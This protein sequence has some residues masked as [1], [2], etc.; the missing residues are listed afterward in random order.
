MT[1]VGGRVDRC[2]GCVRVVAASPPCLPQGTPRA[3]SRGTTVRGEQESVSRRFGARQGCA[4]A[5]QKDQR[6]T[7]PR[8]CRPQPLPW[9]RVVHLAASC[10]PPFLG[11]VSHLELFLS[12]V[13]PLQGGPAASSMGS[14]QHPWDRLCRQL[15][16]PCLSVP[17]L[18]S[19]TVEE[20]AGLNYI[21]AKT[22]VF[23]CP[24]RAHSSSLFST[25]ESGAVAFPT[26]QVCGNGF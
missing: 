18:L 19:G 6:T 5:R 13:L 24:L 2:F 10:C 26:F 8:Q 1:V 3:V 20:A 4:P 22:D 12:C 25:L 11:P 7:L 23:L 9:H 16:A 21:S 15:P 17:P 14:I